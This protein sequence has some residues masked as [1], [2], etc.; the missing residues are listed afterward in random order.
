M[1]LYHLEMLPIEV[2]QIPFQASLK[3]GVLGG[4]SCS[5]FLTSVE[6]QLS[7]V[8]TQ[9]E[10]LSAALPLEKLEAIYIRNKRNLS[11]LQQEM[12]WIV[13]AYSNKKMTAEDSHFLTTLQL[14]AK[15]IDS[16]LLRWQ[17]LLQTEYT[18]LPL[19]T[20]EI[21]H[22]AIS[23][24][25]HRSLSILKRR[26]ISYPQLMEEQKN[27]I[28]TEFLQFSQNYLKKI[29]PLIDFLAAHWKEW[30]A[31]RLIHGRGL[32]IK[33]TYDPLL[34]VLLCANGE[35]YP[36]FGTVGNLLGV[37]SHKMVLRAISL[38]D[39]VIRA[40]VQGSLF[41]TLSEEKTREDPPWFQHM[42]SEYHMLHPMK[43]NRGVIH[44][45]HALPFQTPA[46]K[47]LFLIEDYYWD[48]SL[49]NY[50]SRTMYNQNCPPQAKF[51]KK[52]I[53]KI[54]E[55]LLTGLV[56]LH[57]SGILHHDLKPDN[58]LLNHKQDSIDAVITDFHLASYAKPQSLSQLRISCR[59]SWA[60]PEYAKLALLQPPQYPVS[61]IL[62]FGID[63]WGL[64]L[65][66][67]MLFTSESLPWLA[68]LALS[69]SPE[70]RENA[71]NLIQQEDFDR[72]IF[73]KVANLPE[74]WLPLS[75]RKS[76]YYPLLQSLLAIDLKQRA[77]AK[78]ALAIFQSCKHR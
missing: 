74:D 76:P 12:N 1:D 42:W 45:H 35:C 22:K 21:L 11:I 23:D 77:S 4:I 57:G 63:L 40:V 75:A 52:Q 15:E 58:I 53:E 73:Q 37:G 44:L 5:Q 71:E 31:E 10:T 29:D 67:F 65:I 68:D 36:L 62:S 60:P 39:G 64:G 25:E 55:D 13:E 30:H 46:G 27:K 72:P 50:F 59:A 43:K 20:K 47:D 78:E 56:A 38:K 16:H 19:Q 69:W 8:H 61:D 34:S 66:F 2:N 26:E 17:Q 9:I 6:S 32:W 48:G 24:L 51:S 14:Q 33:E 54:V 18:F 28:K 70:K 49:Q 7:I 3:Q 41:T